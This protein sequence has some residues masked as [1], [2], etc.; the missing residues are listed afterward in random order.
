MISEILN[1]ISSNYLEEKKTS[2]AKNEFAQYVRDSKNILKKSIEKN[3]DHY[4]CKSSP[5]RP[6]HWAAVPWLGVYDPNVTTTSQRGYYICYLFSVDMK[7]VYLTLNQGMTDLQNQL[8]TK[9]ASNELKRRA[10]LIRDRVPEYKKNFEYKPIDLTID[11]AGSTIRPF[12]YEQGHAFGKEYNLQ[13]DLVERELVSDFNNMLQLYKILTFRGGIRTN[14]DDDYID[15]EEDDN[16]SEDIFLETHRRKLHRSVE[17]SS[18]NARK[19]KNKL[20]YTCEVC[21]YNFKEKF[22]KISLNKKNEEFIEAHHKIPVYSLPENEVVE[23]KIEDFA[24]LCS[25]CHRMAHKRKEP[26]TIEDLKNFL[27]ESETK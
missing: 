6:P 25:N 4:L 2:M 15:D 5:G 9:A 8:K 16:E 17:R 13:N 23:F 10:E 21:S 20:G 22:G 26:Y 11:L 12:L 3:T 24:V 27:K 7:R 1:K 18:T 14:T 19:V